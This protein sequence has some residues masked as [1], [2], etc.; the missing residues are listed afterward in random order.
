LCFRFVSTDTRAKGFVFFYQLHF[1]QECVTFLKL[2]VALFE[3]WMIWMALHSEP[4]KICEIRP[5]SPNF[6]L[7]L[8]G[9]D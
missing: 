8:A 1:Y 3:P 5:K 4:A 2:W 9:G 6:G 7:A